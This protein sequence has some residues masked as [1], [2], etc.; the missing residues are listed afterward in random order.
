VNV[1]N[2]T[3]MK[4]LEAQAGHE[5]P[6]EYK[7]YV[8]PLSATDKPEMC[9]FHYD[10]NGGK[11]WDWIAMFYALVSPDMKFTLAGQH[12]LFAK[13]IPR[14]CLPIAGTSVDCILLRLSGDRAGECVIRNW[15][16]WQNSDGMRND[17]VHVV[18]PS[19]TALREM[20]QGDP[21][22]ENM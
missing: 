13:V 21:G 15:E 4:R 6:A 19:F 10:R 20:L 2:E 11:Q 16:D 14:G 22:R 17:G 8:L 1:E 5:I 18:A 9:Y 7:K 3:R 12:D